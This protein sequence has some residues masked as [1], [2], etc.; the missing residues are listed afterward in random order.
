MYERNGCLAN[1]TRRLNGVIRG[2][3]VASGMEIGS[4]SALR[5]DRGGCTRYWRFLTMAEGPKSKSTSSG[6][7]EG[8]RCQ[9][10]II[11]GEICKKI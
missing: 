10:E 2:S 6:A 8:I 4:I 5:G 11:V 9:V 3:R 7:S 1:G